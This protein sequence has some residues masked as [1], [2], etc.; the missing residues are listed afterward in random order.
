MFRRTNAAR[1]VQ[2]R[3]AEDGRVNVVEPRAQEALKRF[4]ISSVTGGTHG[5]H[6]RTVDGLTVRP[7]GQVTDRSSCPWIDAPKSK[8]QSRTT[9]D[10][11]GPSFDP[12]SVGL[13]VD[14]V[15]S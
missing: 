2:N 4:Q 11:H 13:T 8:L 15:S 12:R 14:E 7:A 6:P 1:G 10:Q 5:H 9:V 3:L